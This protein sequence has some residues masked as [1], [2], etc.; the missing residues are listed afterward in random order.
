M[1]FDNLGL[2]VLASHSDEAS[3]ESFMQHLDPDRL[4]WLVN[5]GWLAQAELDAFAVARQKF[6]ESAEAYTLWM[7]VMVCGEKPE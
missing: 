7:M 6:M 1:G 5:G 2:E 3:L 4:A